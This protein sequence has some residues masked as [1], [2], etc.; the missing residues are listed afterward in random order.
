MSKEKMY[1]VELKLGD[2]TFTKYIVNELTL[3]YLMNDLNYDSVKV[4]EEIDILDT[5]KTKVKRKK[6]K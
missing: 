5:G 3:Q 2:Y 6:G 4:I 1:L